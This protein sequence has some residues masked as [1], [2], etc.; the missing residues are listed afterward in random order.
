MKV[1]VEDED[2]TEYE[3]EDKDFVRYMADSHR[4]T[5]NMSARTDGDGMEIDW[6]GILA[7][8][9]RS[10]AGIVCRFREAPRLSLCLG[11]AWNHYVNE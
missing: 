2:E 8:A 1:E 11:H 7:A 3:G 9:Q 10:L 6:G 4:V 5:G